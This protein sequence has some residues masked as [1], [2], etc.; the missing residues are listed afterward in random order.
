[1]KRILFSF[2]AL[3]FTISVYSQP[4][5]T[6]TFKVNLSLYSGTYSNVEF[7]RGGVLYSMVNTI[8]NTYEYA[9]TS[10]WFKFCFEGGIGKC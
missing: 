4:P 2:L 1:M 8:G 6:A 5:V 10:K 7:Y 9:T 3:I